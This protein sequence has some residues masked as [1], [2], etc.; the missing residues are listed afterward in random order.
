[1]DFAMYTIYM[2]YC[3]ERIIMYIAKNI[4]GVIL[5]CAIFLCVCCAKGKDYYTRKANGGKYV[6]NRK[7]YALYRKTASFC[8]KRCLFQ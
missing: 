2:W 6:K 5:L 7:K 8:K 1:M 3:R 4:L